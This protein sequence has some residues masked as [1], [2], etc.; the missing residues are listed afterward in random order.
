MVGNP[1]RV[2]LNRARTALDAGDIAGAVAAVETLKGQ[3]GQAMARWLADAKA[4]VDAR[5]ALAQ[6][7]AQA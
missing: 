6:L 5:S 3:P 2:I 7:A 1:C 4:L